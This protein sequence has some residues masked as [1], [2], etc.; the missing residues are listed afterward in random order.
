MHK[1][2]S[3]SFRGTGQ[4]ILLASSFHKVHLQ[5]ILL[6]GTVCQVGNL[7]PHRNPAPPGF[8]PT[9]LS[10]THVGHLLAPHTAT[11]GCCNGSSTPPSLPCA[12]PQTTCG[13]HHHSWAPSQDK[14]CDPPPHQRSPVHRQCNEVQSYP[15]WG[16]KYAIKEL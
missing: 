8:P 3:G 16:K 12:V 14:P 7:P 11:A 15:T 10:D 5:T 4:L 6:G 1:Y 2:Y 13:S 9:V